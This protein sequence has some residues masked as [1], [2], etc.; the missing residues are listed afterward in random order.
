MDRLVL[1]EHFGHMAKECPLAHFEA[2]CLLWRASGG[3]HSAYCSKPQRCTKQSGC[4]KYFFPLS[5]SFFFLPPFI[6]PQLFVFYILIIIIIIISGSK[7]RM[8]TRGQTGY[9]ANYFSNF[10]SRT[11]AVR[12]GNDLKSL[13]TYK[14]TRML[15]GYHTTALSRHFHWYFYWICVVIVTH[16]SV[17]SIGVC[18]TSRYLHCDIISEIRTAA[19]QRGGRSS[20]L[21]LCSTL[22]QPTQ[23]DI[24]ISKAIFFTEAAASTHLHAC[25]ENFSIF[26]LQSWA[27]T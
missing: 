11:N 24:K 4:A 18:I 13:P 26:M 19:D 25:W 3:L 15:T 20:R 6:H 27:W 16:R 14:S 12:S 2:G 1:T 23:Q 17:V 10:S 9:R 8:R 21:D 22:V 7:N 5:V